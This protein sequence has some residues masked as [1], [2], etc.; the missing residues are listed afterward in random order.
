[1][2]NSGKNIKPGIGLFL[3]FYG[4]EDNNKCVQLEVGYV[5]A[6]YKPIYSSEKLVG[7]ILSQGLVCSWALV[8][9]KIITSMCSLR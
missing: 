3:G 5:A 4:R 6:Q 1:V 9:E 8:E 2:K 7:R